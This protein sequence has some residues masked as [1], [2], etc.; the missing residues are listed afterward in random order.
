MTKGLSSL[1]S[2]EAESFGNI[3]TKV[4]KISSNI[5]NKVLQKAWN[6]KFQGNSTSLKI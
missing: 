3:P 5:F 6:S 4:L 1:N 2:K